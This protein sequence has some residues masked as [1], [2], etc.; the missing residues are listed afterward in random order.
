MIASMKKALRKKRKS[1]LAEE[2]KIEG[3]EQEIESEVQK[4][5]HE[6]QSIKSEEQKIESLEKKELSELSKF[7]KLEKRIEQDVKPKTLGKITLQDMMRSAVG[8]LVGIV[9]HFSFF[10]G[11][12][13]AQQITVVRASF[14]YAFSFIVCYVFIYV[15]GF[16]R[17]KEI[18]T[19]VP[20]RALLIYVVSLVVIVAVL[21]LFGFIIS[22]QWEQGLMLTHFLEYLRC[23]LQFLQLYKFSF[24]FLQCF[25]EK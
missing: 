10:Y 22:L 7:E 5:E 2:Q 14:L 20:M 1:V 15:S 17:V 24:G 4:I 12:E 25:A 21:F 18:R 23:L 8:S 6:E 19:Y 16:R 9:G 13:I 11:V 3:Q